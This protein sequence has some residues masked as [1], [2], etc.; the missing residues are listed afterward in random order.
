MTCEMTCFCAVSLSDTMQCAMSVPLEKIAFG[1]NASFE[2][3][4]PCHAGGHLSTSYD[5][6]G[7]KV[8]AILRDWQEL[9]AEQAVSCALSTRKKVKGREIWST[10]T[11]S[12]IFLILMT[13]TRYVAESF[14]A[15]VRFATVRVRATWR[16][17]RD[18]GLALAVWLCMDDLYGIWWYATC[19]VG[20]RTL[21]FLVF[22][23]VV[24]LRFL[25]IAFPLPS[26]RSALIWKTRS[27]RLM[28]GVG[29]GL[30][31]LVRG[32]GFFIL[33]SRCLVWSLHSHVEVHTDVSAQF[34]ALP[35]LRNPRVVFSLFIAVRLPTGCFW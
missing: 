13:P 15:S 27:A 28:G 3:A 19:G 1:G 16:G 9:D 10:P 21:A 22:L 31:S 29:F 5:T 11:V 12:A 23:L 4:D 6:C 20:I 14:R 17:L 18:A 2:L 7:S 35:P 24:A 33:R 8:P 30:L 26:W 34:G 25:G 32:L